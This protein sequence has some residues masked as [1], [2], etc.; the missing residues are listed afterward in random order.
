MHEDRE[1]RWSAALRA[2]RAGDDAA[3]ARFLAEAAGAVRAAARARLAAMG[4]GAE[5]VEDVV[6]ETLIA[7]HD[8]RHTWDPGRPVTPWL[9]AIA[10]HKTL[11]AAR[12]L[13]RGRRRID[14]RPVE[15]LAEVLAAPAG[16]PHGARRDA[17]ALVARLPARER[18]VVAALAF[19]G[20]SPAAVAERLSIAEGAVRVAFHRGLARI[21]RLAEAEPA[22]APA[23]APA[24]ASA[25]KDA[26]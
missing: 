19:E 23:P 18:G 22:P 21:A 2:A 17:E 25:R 14:G 6:Q 16:P 5:E 15:D 9:R 26:P 3:Y 20:L 10:R 1:R 8:K 11:D 24:R 12:R 13:G 7:L 4:F